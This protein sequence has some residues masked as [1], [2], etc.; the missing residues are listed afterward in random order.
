MTA[1]KAFIK[2]W[3][4]AA[5]V[6]PYG[7]VFLYQCFGYFITQIFIRERNKFDFTL[8]F[9][10]K[11][12][13][14]PIFVYIYLGCYA[15]WIINEII[16]GN[17][18]KE[19]FYKVL[20]TLIICN[21]IATIIFI[22]I[23]TTIE[24]PEVETHSFTGWVLNLVY[25]LDDPVN[26]FPSLHC[27][28]SWLCYIAVRGQRVFSKLYRTFSLI[29]ALLICIST[30]VIKQHYIVDLIAGIFIAELIWF[31]VNRTSCYKP[32]EIVFERINNRLGIKWSDF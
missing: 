12:P 5:A 7:V 20:T 31:I 32:V 8:D 1:I 11:I 14:I 15:F 13:L 29:F 9:D 23:P 30:Q 2:K 22:A 10:R 19:H 24:R 26:L 6:L 17:V 3:I 18:S 4:P 16:C 27:M 21:T 28:V 25:Q